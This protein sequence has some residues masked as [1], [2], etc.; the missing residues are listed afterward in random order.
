ML[1]EMNPEA[2]ILKFSAKRGDEQ[3]EKLLTPSR[4]CQ[5]LKSLLKKRK[6]P[7]RLSEVSAYSVLYTLASWILILKKGVRF[8]E[9]S[10]QTIQDRVREINPEFVGHVKLSLKF[11]ESMVKGSVTSSKELPQVEFIPD[12][13]SE[14]AELRLLSAITKVPKNK[15]TEII[16][17]TLEENLG[18]SGIIF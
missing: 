6:T 7:L 4:C 1:H 5:G 18:K 16:E 15:L 13:K 8:I 9:E 11:P 17:S 14:K 3:F 10:L 12:R 2:R